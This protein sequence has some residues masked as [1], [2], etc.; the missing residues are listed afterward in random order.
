MLQT[1]VGDEVDTLLAQMSGDD[2]LNANNLPIGFA[3][4]TPT[5]VTT[6]NTGTLT[7]PLNAVLRPDRLVMG[8]ASR[9][10]LSRVNQ[11]AVGTVNLNV[12]TQ[13]SPCEAFSPDAIG[14]R[15]RA[16]VT[17]T[18]S[19]PPN[20]TVYNGTGG[21]IVYEGVFFGPVARA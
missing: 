18:P 16:A 17:G 21:T 5:S 20:V 2:E 14:T 6:L 10:A 13:S 1:I 11:I 15:L 12:G 8:T 4:L 9:V 3:G 19:V 7:C